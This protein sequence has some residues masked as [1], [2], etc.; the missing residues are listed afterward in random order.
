MVRAT[1]ERGDGVLDYN[2]ELFGS[3]RERREQIIEFDVD[4]HAYSG[5][6]SLRCFH[7]NLSHLQPVELSRLYMRLTASTG[8][9][10]VTYNGYGAQRFTPPRGGHRAAHRWQGTM[11]ITPALTMMDTKLFWPYTTTLLELRIDRE[12]VAD[13]VLRFLEA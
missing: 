6:P 10:L 1:D 7:V 9:Q 2:L 8:T 11:D 5:D 12:P 13:K 4:V 3:R